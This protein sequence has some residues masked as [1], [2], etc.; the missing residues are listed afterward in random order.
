MSC[1]LNGRIE[2]LH[3]DGGKYEP[4]G[5]TMS[6]LASCIG[7]SWR[8]RGHNGTLEALSAM[9]QPGGLV[10]VGELFWRAEPDP[11]Y[12]KLK[13]SGMD[14]SSLCRSVAIAGL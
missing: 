12:L 2:L 10:L 4:D 8:Y 11:D 7:A 14:A 3:L 9:V 13:R 5:G 1:G 6:D